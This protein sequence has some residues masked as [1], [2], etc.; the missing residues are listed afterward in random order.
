MSDRLSLMIAPNWIIAGLSTEFH[1]NAVH[2]I[3]CHLIISVRGGL[4]LD[5]RPDDATDYQSGGQ[6]DSS[7]FS[8]KNSVS[9]SSSCPSVASVFGVTWTSWLERDT[10]CNK[11]LLNVCH[12]ERGWCPRI[13][14]FSFSPIV[15]WIA[16]DHPPISTSSPE[17]LLLGI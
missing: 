1:L 15:I 6:W 16:G 13:N 12:T 4:A 17:L 7:S 8:N 3:S 14:N 11:L 9:S 2:T 10:C 5:T